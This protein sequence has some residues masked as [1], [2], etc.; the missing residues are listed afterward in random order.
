MSKSLGNVLDPLDLIDEYGADAVR[1]TLAS[2]AGMGRDI[3]LSKERIAGNRNFATKIWNAFRFAEM[4]GVFE[5]PVQDAAPKASAAANRW[6]LGETGRIRAETDAALDA[7]RF[8]DAAN[9]LYAHVWG[10]VCDWYLEFAKPLLDGPEAGETR[11]TLRFVLD[12]CLIL[13]HPIMPFVTET[14]WQETGPKDENR[15]KLLAHADWPAYGTELADPEAMREMGWVIQLIDEIRSARAQLHVPAGLQLPMVLTEADDTARAAWAQNAALIKRLARIDNLTEGKAP[16]GAITIT[17]EGA[18]FALP[19]EGVIDVAE[20]KSRLSKT[21][22][23]LEKDLNGLRGRLNNPKFVES[24][25]D[26][27]V[28]ETREKLSLG[29]EDAAKLRNALKRLA[30]IG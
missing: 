25:P 2:M 7:F 11:A 3:K 6:I 4:N 18:A 20:E 12:Q 28:E 24:A 14:L 17:V 29:E 5:L 16:K 9:G 19:L 10:K 23:K 22:E 13:L 21:L 15:A 27:V 30:D 8:N 26:D 1:F